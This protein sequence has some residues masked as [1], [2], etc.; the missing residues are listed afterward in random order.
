[1]RCSMSMYLASMESSPAMTS[2]SWARSR[3]IRPST[4]RRTASAASCP[5][6]STSVSSAESSSWNFFRSS[7]ITRTSP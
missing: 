4:D 7:T 3:R 6:V 5:S 2:S 1:M